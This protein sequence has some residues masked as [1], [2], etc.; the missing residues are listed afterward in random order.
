[1]E[2]GEGGVG[3]CLFLHRESGSGEDRS[4]ASGGK[5]IH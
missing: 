1:M 4:K 3:G 2:D 5:R